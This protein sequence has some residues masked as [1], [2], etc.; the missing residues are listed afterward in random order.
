MKYKAQKFNLFYKKRKKI[1][2]IRPLLMLNRLHILKICIFLRLPLSIDATNQFANFRRNR[3][4]HQIFPLF[5]TFFNPKIDVAL[6]R[7]IAINNSET[8]Y[9][10]NHLKS[11]KKFIQIKN[12]N[13]KKIQTLKWVVF[14][15]KALQ[16]RFY[17]SL[18]S[19][20][21]KS[22]TFNEIEFLLRV[23]ICIFK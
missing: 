2:I 17:Q 14:L 7:F 1:H 18:L 9:F 23:N 10:N 11:I 4:R 22:L 3:L 16:R 12:F 15:P 20:S 19:S 21:I 8:T 6:A 13:S 5:K